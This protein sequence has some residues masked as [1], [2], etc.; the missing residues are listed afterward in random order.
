MTIW[1][2]SSQCGQTQ[3][4]SLLLGGYSSKRTLA[5]MQFIKITDE[6]H[7]DVELLRVRVCGARSCQVVAFPDSVSGRTEDD[8]VCSSADCAPGTVSHCTF[9]AIDSGTDAVYMNTVA[10]T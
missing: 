3:L 5:P 7:Y 4:G 9:T 8:C 2:P 1:Q 10:N 6:I